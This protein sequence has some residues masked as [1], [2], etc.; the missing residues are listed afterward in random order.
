MPAAFGDSVDLFVL[1]SGRP[2][3]LAGHCAPLHDQE[4]TRARPGESSIGRRLF[5]TP[6]ICISALDDWLF[7][8]SRP[9]DPV[10]CLTDE[11]CIPLRQPHANFAGVFPSHCVRRFLT[12]M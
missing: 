11:E 8:R 1:A 9:R 5:V 2:L 12:G 3:G 10:V 7:P 4:L 6:G